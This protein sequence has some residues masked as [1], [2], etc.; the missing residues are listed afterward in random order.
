MSFREKTAWVT[1]ITLIALTVLFILH[2][3]RP[4]TLAPPANLFL[5]HVLILSILTF[6][7]V[8]VVAHIVIAIRA[9]DDARAPKDERER[10]IEL[11][12]TAVAAYVYAFLSLGSV[13][14]TIHLG[15]NV[16]MIAYLVL[17]SFVL[18]QIANYTMRVIYYRRGF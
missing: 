8:E 16:I 10:L 7:V 1:L 18:A 2:I 14:I 5:F 4:Y 3:P 9:P 11:K 12:S 6:V 17:F 13:F 15:A